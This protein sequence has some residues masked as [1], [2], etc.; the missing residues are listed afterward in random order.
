MYWRSFE[1]EGNDIFCGFNEIIIDTTRSYFRY[2]PSCFIFWMIYF[3]IISE[4]NLS[5][6]AFRWSNFT[7]LI[8]MVKP[9]K[10]SIKINLFKIDIN[11]GVKF[12]ENLVWNK[13][14][15]ADEIINLVSFS[16]VNRSPPPYEFRI[17][18]TNQIN[19]AVYCSYRPRL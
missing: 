10:L 5:T 14:P 12:Y 3:R 4:L 19:W 13:P 7:I 9:I 2:A 6:Y 16:H 1:E 8:L 15:S 17:L 18:S 11:K